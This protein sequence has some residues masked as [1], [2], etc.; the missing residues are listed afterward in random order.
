M[1]KNDR[2]RVLRRSQPAVDGRRIAFSFQYLV[3]DQGRF[4]V[5]NC[6]QDYM[7]SL[8]RAMQR[9]SGYTVE[10]FQTMDTQDDPYRHP[11]DFAGSAEPNGFPIDPIDDELF[12]DPGDC[13]QFGLFDDDDTYSYTFRV[14]GFIFRGIFF[15]V[16]LD[17]AHRLFGKDG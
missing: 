8:L 9:Y 3:S 10:Q 6:G 15:V 11:I 16:W 17:P 7:D 5:S 4:A 12:T 14:H 1:G 2:R 13:W